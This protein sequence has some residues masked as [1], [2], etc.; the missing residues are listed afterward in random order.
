MDSIKYLNKMK[1]YRLKQ[2]YPSL[3]DWVK[4]N[5]VIVKLD[6]HD[7]FYDIDIGYK[8]KSVSRNEVEN[9]PDFWEEVR[10]PLFT[11]EDGRD[12]YEGDEY[13][14]VTQDGGSYKNLV[15]KRNC[16]GLTS[17]KRFWML[18]NAEKYIES[19]K[20]QK[21]PLFTTHDGVDIHNGDNYWY[22]GKYYTIEFSQASNANAKLY[23]NNPPF[24]FSSRE[25]AVEYK[26]EHMPKYS[27]HDIRKILDEWDGSNMITVVQRDTIR[28]KF[29]IR[30]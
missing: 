18:V 15:A 2:W 6:P 27:V 20:A 29:G 11:T 28:E 4:N 5:E 1:Q 30:D 26:L 14:Y 21:K 16:K 23:K 24:R 8:G 22:L 3:P 10:K 13:F 17:S 25:K 19:M 7:N 12:I 9:N